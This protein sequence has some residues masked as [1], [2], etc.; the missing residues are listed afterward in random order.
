NQAAKFRYM[1]GGKAVTPVVVRTMYG[2]GLRAAAQHSQC[3][4]PV[5][6]HIPGLKVVTP[7]TPYDAKGLLIQAIRDDDPV[8]FCEHKAL[9]DT[10]GEVPEESYAIP[11]GE[12]N[13]V[14]EGGDVTIVTLGRM[15][16]TSLAAATELAAAGIE[17]EVIDLRTT[18]PM[19]VDTI[20]ESVENTG[21]LVVVDEATP[22][23]NIATDVSALVAQQAFSALAAPIEMVTAPHTP[24]PFA[25]AL[26]D[27]FIP[28]AQRVVNAVKSVAGWTR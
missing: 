2:A 15:V 6:T 23:C 16:H 11:F 17:C 24:V 5:F 27:L 14:R 21:R 9:Y 8:I 18:S 20:L 19:D 1:F 26:E 22:R 28:D 4:Y 25:D 3:L 13:V 12:A 10:S 7:A